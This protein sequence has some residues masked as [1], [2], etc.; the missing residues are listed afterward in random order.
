MLARKYMTKW[1]TVTSTPAYYTRVL[2]EC[3]LLKSSTKVDSWLAHKY[4][5]C[6]A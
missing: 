5:T 3:L 4:M 6:S 1:L 2:L